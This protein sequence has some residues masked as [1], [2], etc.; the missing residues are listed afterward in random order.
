[1]LLSQKVRPSLEVPIE[2]VY[3]EVLALSP[4]SWFH[5]YLQPP[6]FK[7]LSRLF[8]LQSLMQQP[9]LCSCLTKNL[10]LSVALARVISASSQCL[11]NANVVFNWRSLRSSV[12]Y[13]LCWSWSSWPVTISYSSS[14]A[15]VGLGLVLWQKLVTET[16]L[17]SQPAGP[18][19][20]VFA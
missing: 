7:A 10:L 1:M 12:R 15:A 18:T 4:H 14:L 13:F 9:Y 16:C 8:C 2:T 11:L 5:P 19:Y 6:F 3:L 17:F 20:V